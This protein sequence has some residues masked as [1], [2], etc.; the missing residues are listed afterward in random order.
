MSAESEAFEA[1][2]EDY[3]HEHCEKV[4]IRGH[5]ESEPDKDGV[6][7]DSDLECGEGEHIA[8]FAGIVVRVRVDNIF[9]PRL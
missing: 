7:E 1:L 6:E 4:T 5:Y 8:F 3:H 9:W 2:V